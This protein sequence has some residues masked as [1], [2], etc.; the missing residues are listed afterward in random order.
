MVLRLLFRELLQHTDSEHPDYCNLEKAVLAV[1]KQASTL[2][3][4][5]TVTQSIHQVLL[6]QQSLV[7]D[8]VPVSPRWTG[9][10]LI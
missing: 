7:G 5:I 8:G 6:V 2:N 4:N 9:L 10:L 1:A 3:K